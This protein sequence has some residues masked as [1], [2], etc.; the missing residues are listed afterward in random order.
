MKYRTVKAIRQELEK[1]GGYL[2]VRRE[3]V[4]PSGVHPEYAPHL[5]SNERG[6]EHGL[7]I[8]DELIQWAN[9]TQLGT[10]KHPDWY[11]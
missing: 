7:W 3:Y 1:R 5:F 2:E 4:S 6:W 10:I 9:E 11:R 8:K